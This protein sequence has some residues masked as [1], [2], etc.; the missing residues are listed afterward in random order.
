MNGK[1]KIWYIPMIEYYSAFKK[2][3]A[4]PFTTTWM[5]PEGITLNEITQMEKDKYCLMPLT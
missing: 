5:N 3:E 4:V 1:K 2:N